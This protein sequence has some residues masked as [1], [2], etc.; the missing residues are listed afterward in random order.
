M[1]KVAKQMSKSVVM[2]PHKAR[3]VKI[4]LSRSFSSTDFGFK[5]IRSE[6]KERLVREVFSKVATNYD[7]MNDAM[8]MGVHRLWKDELIRMLGYQG[9]ARH[10]PSGDYLPRHL[11]V[12]GGTGDIAFRSMKAMADCYGSAFELRTD[13]MKF[14]EGCYILNNTAEHQDQEESDMH[15]HEGEDGI[16]T[17]PHDKQVV[18][19]DIN[20]EMLAV[21]ES[22][23]QTVLGAHLADKI[24]FV[25]GNAEKLPF[26]DDSFDIY[27]IAFGLRNVTNKDKALREAYRVLRKGG[28]LCVLEFSHLP[29]TVMQQV[30]D[31][32]SFNVI[33][34]LGEAI[35]NDYDSYQYLVESIRKFPKQEELR[36]MLTEAGFSNSEFTNMTLGVVAVHSGFKL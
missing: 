27:T 1:L 13:H 3:V 9:A 19:C 7:V 6:E 2:S 28:R 34:K 20:P 31:Q 18:V 26:D 29:N 22:R 12:A 14:G 11:D 25:E 8:S 36:D 30:Y 33:P 21:G 35:S 5:E 24:G 15:H 10:D 17:R 32:Y 4:D 23:A 16:I